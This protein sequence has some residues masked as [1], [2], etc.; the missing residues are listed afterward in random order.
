MQ[1]AKT[2]QEIAN[3]YGIHRNTFYT[4][5]K[6]AEIKLSTRLVSPKEQAII[7]AYFGQ[8]SKKKVA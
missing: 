1:K 7:Y 5:L 2:R 8:P 4:W 3:E 6:T